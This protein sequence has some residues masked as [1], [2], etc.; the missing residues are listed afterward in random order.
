MIAFK[1][2]PCLG[3]LT[4]KF[5]AVVHSPLQIKVVL[6]VIFYQRVLDVEPLAIQC[7]LLLKILITIFS[8]SV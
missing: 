6:S 3:G 5:K 2:H 4:N 7:P 1:A 8:V